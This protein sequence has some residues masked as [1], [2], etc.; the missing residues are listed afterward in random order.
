MS[1]GREEESTESGRGSEQTSKKF[2]LCARSLDRP[3]AHIDRHMSV[4]N[5]R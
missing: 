3:P 2:F 5:G 1:R 4:S